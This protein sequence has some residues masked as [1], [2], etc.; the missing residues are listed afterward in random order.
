MGAEGLVYSA[1]G[2]RVWN[3]VAEGMADLAESCFDVVTQKS[4]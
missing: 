2:M 3:V 1:T 4:A